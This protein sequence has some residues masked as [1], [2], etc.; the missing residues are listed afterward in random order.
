MGA[1]EER[2]R[3]P[4]PPVVM[5]KVRDWPEA[6]RKAEKRWGDHRE[7][8]GRSRAGKDPRKGGDKGTPPSI[9]SSR[10]GRL[11]VRSFQISWAAG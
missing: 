4:L 11:R 5:A 2:R 10:N 3:I 1:R 9:W 6:E 7:G 8:K